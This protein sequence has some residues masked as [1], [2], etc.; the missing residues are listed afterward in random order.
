MKQFLARW[1]DKLLRFFCHGKNEQGVLVYS[2]KIPSRIKAW[3]LVLLCFLI[4]VSATDPARKKGFAREV[5]RY[6]FLCTVVPFILG[7]VG[8]MFNFRRRLSRLTTQKQ[9]CESLG[10]TQEELYQFGETNGIKP[11]INLNGENYYDLN[12]FGDAVTLLRASVPPA[13]TPETLLR[14]A[15]H[16]ESLP[17]QLLRATSAEVTENGSETSTLKQTA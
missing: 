11:S 15:A 1:S 4:I 16:T 14:P 2:G 13:A 7:Q 3:G 12:D 5:K 8:M 10:V 17:E 9:L 6:I